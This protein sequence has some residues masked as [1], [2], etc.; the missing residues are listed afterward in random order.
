MG[1]V[2]WPKRR[3][4]RWRIATKI[5]K[6]TVIE[7]EEDPFWGAFADGL[8]YSPFKCKV[9]SKA[10]NEFRGFRIVG[11]NRSGGQG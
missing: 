2:F 11:D 9:F 5:R 3:R 6:H 4:H 1:E 7:Y 10:D 8:T